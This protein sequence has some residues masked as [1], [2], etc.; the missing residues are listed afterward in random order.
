M[1]KSVTGARNRRHPVLGSSHRMPCGRRPGAED[2]GASESYPAPVVNLQHFLTTGTGTRLTIRLSRLL[3]RRL[4]HRLI[5]IVT[6]FIAR[7]DSHMTRIVRSNLSV[8]LD[9]KP[10]DH[11][12]DAL[13]SEVLFQSA[14]GTFDFFRALGAPAHENRRLVDMSQGIWDVL[15]PASRNGRGLLVVAPHLGTQDLGGIGFAAG[16]ASYEV[17]VLSYALPPSG[18]ELVNDLRST[19]GLILTPSS[20]DALRQAAERLRAGGIVFTSLDRPPPR[21]R[22]AQTADFFG[23]PARLWD[24]F[25]RLAASTDSLLQIIWVERLPDRRYRLNLVRQLD[26][27]TMD[28]ANPAESLWKATLKEAEAMIREHPD[29]WLMF[30]SVWPETSQ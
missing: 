28:G 22:R 11:R 9:T 27:R 24:G 2:C 19:E 26:P 16:S 3:P 30:F 4:G 12:L 10:D 14:S 18:Y 25:A 15:D 5:R 17:Q 1:S 8:V 23:K 7:R 20:G 6:H 29:Q 21:G 13:V